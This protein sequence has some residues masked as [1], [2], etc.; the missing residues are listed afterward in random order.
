MADKAVVAVVCCSC[1]EPDI[2]FDSVHR[3]VELLG[4]IGKFI[5]PGKRVLVN[6]N[7]LADAAVEE[8]VTTHPLIVEA[9]IRLIM[10]TGCIVSA[11]DS[12]SVSSS[13]KAMKK[14]GILKVIEDTGA[15]VADFIEGVPVT[16][17]GPSGVG[18]LPI[19]RGFLDADITVSLPK[20]KTHNLFPITAA[21]KNVYGIIPGKKKAFL[22]LRYPSQRDFAG[23]IA[24]L[25]AF[26]KPSLHI[27]DAVTGM[28]GTGPRSG[29]PRHI[30]LIMASADPVA[31]DT[32]ACLITGIDPRNLIT[33]RV[34]AARGLGVCNPDAIEVRGESLDNI[35][36][37]KFQLTPVTA[38]ERIP[39]PIR[40]FMTKSFTADPAVKRELC[41]GCGLCVKSCPADVIS[42][43]SS[44]PD[45]IPLF[46]RS[47]CI[48]CYC[49]LEACPEGAL[50]LKSG[51]LR[52]FFIK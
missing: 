8:A 17:E 21:V 43:D 27:M 39:Y 34:A 45:S 28:D 40:R 36:V 32:I 49:C 38:L 15:E 3:A 51:F 23:L 48:H 26:V 12:P 22:H 42:M 52:R 50:K 5:E 2:V 20:L 44:Q 11:G 10:D 18:V 19:A 14:S 37:K 1:Y 29:N 47:Q 13:E 31:M 41:T 35:H 4:G 46:R 7:V 25:H 6:P 9:V 24:D 33:S 16:I 30:G